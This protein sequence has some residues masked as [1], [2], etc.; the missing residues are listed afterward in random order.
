MIGQ[1]RRHGRS[2]GK[3][4]VF[5]LT[6]F[7]MHKAEVI[8][9]ANQVHPRFQRIQAMGGM[10]TFARESRQPFARKGLRCRQCRQL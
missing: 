10:P 6:E 1:S 8:G 7:V 2:T 5:G 4:K 3:S 9:T